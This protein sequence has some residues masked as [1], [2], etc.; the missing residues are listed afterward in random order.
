MYYVVTTSV[1]T[2]D[3][4]YDINYARVEEEHCT[5]RS[6]VYLHSS[7]LVYGFPSVSFHRVRFVVC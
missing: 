3:K 1:L 4:F 5:V 7:R 6:T 2:N